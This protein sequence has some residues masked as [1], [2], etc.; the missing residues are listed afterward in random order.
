MKN[1]LKLA[2]LCLAVLGLLAHD[3]LIKY[4]DFV[5]VRSPCAIM[6]SVNAT[7]GVAPSVQHKTYSSLSTIQ[8][9]STTTTMMTPTTTFQDHDAKPKC[10]LDN[11]TYQWYGNVWIP[12]VGVPL[13]NRYD[14]IRAF[15][16]FD[17]LWIGD[18]TIRR[19]YGTIYALL[20]ASQASLSVEELDHPRVLDVNKFGWKGYH[21]NSCRVQREHSK[22]LVQLEKHNLYG[23]KS[24]CRHVVVA[25]GTRRKAFDFVR[26]DCLFELRWIADQDWVL[27]GYSLVIIGMGIHDFL[28]PR[29]G[30]T[31]P[32]G[33]HFHPEKSFH[34]LNQQA[35]KGLQAA[36]KIAT[37]LWNQSQSQQDPKETDH[38]TTT[39]TTK[40]DGDDDDTPKSSPPTAVLW[41]T[42]GFDANNDTEFSKYGVLHLNQLSV[43]FIQQNQ[44]QWTRNNDTVSTPLARL[45]LVDWGAAVFPRSFHPNKAESDI[46]VHY[47]LEPRLLMAQMTT[48][49]LF[50]I[51]EHHHSSPSSSSFAV[52]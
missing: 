39:T 47:G 42:A 43:D 3:V 44:Q 14:M 20:N 25:G 10:P 32:R 27:Q 1:A 26:A 41:R 19:A 8:S 17:T 22:P 9:N 12:P 13:Y 34:F 24:M 48:Q 45:T 35:K 51:L 46:S 31:P 2:A 33:L 23:P 5:A 11:Q 15:S 16:Q 38:P 40:G 37:T 6:D 50:N 7:L 18:S 30:S 52:R 21:E 28:Q 29:C 49:Q 36:Q 4:T